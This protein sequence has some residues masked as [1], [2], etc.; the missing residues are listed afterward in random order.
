LCQQR[1]EPREA[2][3][4][5]RIVRDFVARS[6]SGETAP[7]ATLVNVVDEGALTVD[8]DHRKP[9]AVP[10]LEIRVSGD[11]HLDQLEVQLV[12]QTP[13]HLLRALAQMAPG[14]VVEGDR[15]SWQATKD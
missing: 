14:R 15:L 7:Q 10:S 5:A 11:V 2:T 9:L 8:L 6:N 12:T 4:R 3:R 1:Y 13:E